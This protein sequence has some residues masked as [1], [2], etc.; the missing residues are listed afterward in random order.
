MLAATTFRCK[1]KNAYVALLLVARLVLQILVVHLLE[2]LLA[3]TQEIHLAG[4]GLLHLQLV[5]SN[6]QA[7]LF[8]QVY[9]CPVPQL[10]WEEHPRRPP[11][12]WSLISQKGLLVEDHRRSKR[13]CVFHGQ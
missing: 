13:Q 11:V 9:L 6:P 5:H 4:Q 2:I 8:R 7:T 10:M 12:H 1:R 3:G